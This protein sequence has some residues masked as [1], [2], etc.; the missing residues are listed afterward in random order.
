MINSPSSVSTSS[1][2]PRTL[3]EYVLTNTH[4]TQP[5]NLN[6][7]GQ[8]PSYVT[9]L[10]AAGGGD[11]TLSKLEGSEHN[12]NVALVQSIPISTSTI[13]QQP[14]LDG[15]QSVFQIQPSNKPSSSVRPAVPLRSKVV[16]GRQT[17]ARSRRSVNST[18]AVPPA[19]VVATSIVDP[20]ELASINSLSGTP[21]LFDAAGNVVASDSIAQAEIDQSASQNSYVVDNAGLSSTG[22][23]TSMAITQ[24]STSAT[25]PLSLQL[26]NDARSVGT[27]PS[28]IRGLPSPQR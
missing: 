9:V 5:T 18:Y 6:T 16:G 22:S 24:P 1:L 14:A 28:P 4:Q 23:S 2:S 7:H 12:P 13:L 3:E 11:T 15:S 26:G 19:T 25:S 17:A 8:P 27:Y 20:T 21:V 10:E